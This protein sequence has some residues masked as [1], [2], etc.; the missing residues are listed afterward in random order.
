MLSGFKAFSQSDSKLI[1]IPQSLLVV[2]GAR[3]HK[4]AIIELLDRPV[5]QSPY[6]PGPPNEAREAALW[7]DFKARLEPI[8]IEQDADAIQV[9][10]N[11][12][13][14]GYISRNL[15]KELKP[16]L[17]ES[18]SEFDCTIF[19]NGDPHADYQF[20]TVQLFS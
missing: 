13:R 14:V 9:M 18:T 20:Y 16:F 5:P 7:G 19:W 4:E 11:G 1:V 15:T 2:R 6:N 17:S 3:Y 10:V 8:D 12:K